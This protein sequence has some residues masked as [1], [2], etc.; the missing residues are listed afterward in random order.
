MGQRHWVGVEEPFGVNPEMQVRHWLE[1]VPVQV[2]QVS[3]QLTQVL[4]VVE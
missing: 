3:W 4:V 2:W 1:E